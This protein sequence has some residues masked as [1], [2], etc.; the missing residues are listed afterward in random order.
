TH[1]E[2]IILVN[3]DGTAKMLPAPEE[4]ANPRLR[5]A[6]LPESYDLR[7]TEQVLPVQNQAYG[8]CWAYAATTA[9]AGVARTQQLS[10]FHLV[11]AAFGPLG[12][13]S[14]TVDLRNAGGSSAMVYGAWAHYYGPRY[15]SAF[16]GLTSI[17]QNTAEIDSRDLYFTRGQSYPA[18]YNSRGSYSATATTNV[19][20]AIMDKGPVEVDWAASTSRYVNHTTAADPNHASVIVGW[21]DTIPA[22]SFSQRPA[23]DGAW[24][25]QNSWGTSVGD[26]GYQWLSYYD[27]SIYRFE[28]YELAQTSIAGRADSHADNGAA[29]VGYQGRDQ[30]VGE[31]F[32]APEYGT[33]VNG[34]MVSNGGSGNSYTVT[35]REYAGGLP[36]SGQVLASATRSNAAIGIE[37]V[38]FA[39]PAEIAP[40]ATYSI[41]VEYTIARTNFGGALI[42]LEGDSYISGTTPADPVQPGRAYIGFGSSEV[43]DLYQE[44]GLGDILLTSLNTPATEPPDEPTPDPTPEPSDVIPEPSEDPTPDSSGEPTPETSNEPD[45]EPSDDA[46]PD[47]TDS[48]TPEPSDDPS[49]EATD[50]PTPE[51]S[52]DPSP[53]SSE[54]ANPGPA[55]SNTPNPPASPDTGSGKDP[56]VTPSADPDPTPSA[57]PAPVP[58]AQGTVEPAQEEPAAEITWT[59]SEANPQPLVVQTTSIATAKVKVGAATWTGKIAKPAV[60]VTLGGK[61]LKSGTDY[62][63]TA[64]SW[65]VG[66]GTLHLAGIGK[67]SGYKAVAYRILPKTTSLKATKK[68]ATAKVTVAKVKALR[69]AYY[70]IQ[71]RAKGSATWKSVKTTATKITLKKLAASKKYVFRVRTAVRVSGTPWYSAWSKAKTA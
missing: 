17:L 33:T 65:S 37:T 70:H 16:P 46:K 49:P 66:Y 6:A 31:V 14:Q 9:A 48:P 64:L 34:A 54:T 25:L 38:S 35:V 68:G 12:A 71:Y 50:S 18:P 69:G 61:T 51:P 53:E 52:D 30:W 10:P 36:T 32:T 40:G 13:S 3:E 29:M 27:K 20:Q 23:G 63:A 24:L 60:K 57:A 59:H 1:P 28:L 26:A 5:A 58:E 43:Y 42:E 11:S 45:P 7:G 21:D 4:T 2:V 62:K 8:T 19:K 39:N 67:Y 55:D 47:S 22:A 41:V 15:D 56:T 44:A